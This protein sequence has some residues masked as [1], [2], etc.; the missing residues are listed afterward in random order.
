MADIDQKAMVVEEDDRPCHHG[1]LCQACSEKKLLQTQLC[2][3]RTGHCRTSFSAWNTCSKSVIVKA[4]PWY[5]YERFGNST[6]T[7]AQVGV[8]T[9][10]LR[11]TAVV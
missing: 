2:L 10:A 8:T 3:K 9:D 5:V 7:M 6:A 11:Y 1:V 4:V